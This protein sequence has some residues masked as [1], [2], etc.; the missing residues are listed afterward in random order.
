MSFVPRKE[1]EAGRKNSLLPCALWGHRP[2]PSAPQHFVCQAILYGRSSLYPGDAF[3]LNK[4]NFFNRN[5]HVPLTSVLES[6]IS[7]PEGTGMKAVRG[8]VSAFGN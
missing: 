6:G 2:A 8:G 4:V 7:F 1:Q 3:Q 5:L